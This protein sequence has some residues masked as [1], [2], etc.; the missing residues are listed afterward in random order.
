MEDRTT[1]ALEATTRDTLRANKQGGES[2]DE[3]INRLLTENGGVE[4]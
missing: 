2:Y 1:I 4:G 3:A